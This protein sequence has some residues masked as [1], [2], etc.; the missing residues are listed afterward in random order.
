MDNNW[1]TKEIGERI[2]ARCQ[3][4]AKFSES[5]DKLTRVY[6]SKEHAQCNQQV[7]RWMHEAGM[8]TWQ[9]AVGN[10]CARYEG[11][12]SGAPALLLGSHLD[13][14]RNAGKYDG[15]AGVLTAIEVVGKLQQLDIRLPFAIEVVGFAD[16]EGTRFGSTLLGSR[17]L[18]GQWQP[19]WLQL[20][21]AEKITIAQALETFGL[22]PEKIAQATRSAD[23]FIGYMEVHIEQGPQLECANLAAGV[24]SAIN[25]A[26]R[27]Q[28]SV[29][30]QAGH[31]GTVP[32][33]MRQDA[34]VGASEIVLCIEQIAKEQQVVATVG[35]LQCLPDSVNVIP[36]QVQFSLDIRSSDDA[37]R[38]RVLAQIIERA[39]EIAVHRSLEFSQH[40]F[41][42]SDATECDSYLQKL[43]NDACEKI[44][45]R[46]MTLS[47][48]AGHDAMAI[49]KL[50]PVAMLFLRCAKGISHHPSEAVT[51][52]DLAIGWQVL[53]QSVQQFA[54]DYSL[55]GA[56]ASY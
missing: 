43:L 30:G 17:G 9:D 50:C 47:S 55:H 41:Y 15:I 28:M 56:S 36:G 53:Y 5:S 3:K 46:S 35:Q 54:A 51:A 13:T 25:G 1:H 31:A 26:K 10:L 33:N 42:Q 20:P 37:H 27:M 48:G 52:N 40:C 2:Y 8:S 23:D 14:V 12:T 32:M 45:G 38:D 44:Q 7:A 11:Q 4:L 24:V 16:E 29:T 21:D 6:L 19:Q 49:A 34:L 18:T 39:R 22:A